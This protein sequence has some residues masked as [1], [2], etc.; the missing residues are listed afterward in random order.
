MVRL[1]D[2]DRAL[3]DRDLIAEGHVLVRACLRRNQP[4]PF[5]I[6]AAI[7]AVHD[8]APTATATD[9][10]QVVA[11]YDQLFALRQDPVV[12]MNRAVAV[13]ELDGATAGLVALAALDADQ[14]RSYQPFHAVHAD[15]L[16][17]AGRYEEA[18]VA[19]TRAI[20]LTANP[21]ERSFLEA[22]RAKAAQP[23]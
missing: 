4:G 19:Y 16:V 6:Q 8:D 3:W 23:R 14:L 21:A 2:Q 5:Q 12:A 20:D 11:L 18:V 17:R 1:A 22:Q 10:R 9:W 13:G 15:L 7:A